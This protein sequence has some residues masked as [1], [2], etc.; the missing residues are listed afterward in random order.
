L[1]DSSVKHVLVRHEQ[2]AVHAASGFARVSGKTGVCMATSGP[3]ATNLV[4][5]IANAYMDSIPIVI[6]TGQVSTHMVGTDAFQEVDITGITHPITK[7]NYLVQDANDIPRVFKEAFHIAGTGRPGPVLVDIPKNVAESTCKAGIPQKTSLAG[8]KPTFKG[9]PTQVK[10]AC[11]LMREAKKP[12]IHAGGG[13]I[14]AGAGKELVQLAELLQAPVTTTL[15]GLGSIPSGHYLSLGMLGIHGTSA[16]NN[17]VTECDLLI[18]VG[19]RFDDRV[20]GLVAKFAPEAKVVHIDIDPAE[21]GKN[22][23]VNVPIVGDVKII[24]QAIN[25]HLE[26]ISRPEWLARVKY[27]Q[28]KLCYTYPEVGEELTCRRVIQQL[29]KLTGGEVIFTTDVGQHQMFAAQFCQLK[30]PKSF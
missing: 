26:Q 7:H 20:T 30:N 27:W 28:E 18:S 3:G 5:G 13:I 14:N 22:V 2:A 8:Y 29:N 10:T 1:I 16:A 25:N 24:L 15:M 4:T 9:H 12:V 21:I 23:R 17:S 19:A 11:S 6:I